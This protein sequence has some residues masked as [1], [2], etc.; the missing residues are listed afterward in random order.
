ML[1]LSHHLEMILS[2]GVKG[3][4]LC[5]DGLLKPTQESEDMVNHAISMLE[6]ELGTPSMLSVWPATA[7]LEKLGTVHKQ[8]HT[9]P[10]LTAFPIV[11]LFWTSNT[12]C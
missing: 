2:C 10:Q 9:N 12:F 3:Y 5:L 7:L 11:F 4:S 6:E 1:P 8:G